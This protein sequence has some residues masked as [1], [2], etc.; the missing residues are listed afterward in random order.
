[1]IKVHAQI[2]CKRPHLS[3]VLVGFLL[4]QQ[5]GL[6]DFSYSFEEQFATENPYLS[7]LFA[8]IDGKKVVFDMNDGYDFSFEAVNQ[9]LDNTDF[10]FKR[11][12]STEKNRQ[13]SPQNRSKLYRW[14]LN[15]HVTCPGNPLDQ[16]TGWRALKEDIFQIAANGA[17]RSYFTPERFE[18]GAGEKSAG[19]ILFLARLWEPIGEPAVDEDRTQINRMRIALVERMRREY[20]S[21]F[22]GGIQ[23]SAYAKKLAPELLVPVAMTRRK[24]FLHTVKSCD[25][26]IGT[27][28]LF[29][30]VGWKTTEYV[31]AARAIINEKL[32]YEAPGDFSSPKNYL[33]FLTADDCMEKTAYLLE[34]P[35]AVAQ[36][37]RQNEAYYQQWVRPD[38]KMRHALALVCGNG[39]EV[40]V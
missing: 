26:C 29:G 1:M 34:H 20:G 17:R 9:I 25:I 30:S 21:R 4:L 7:Y 10:Y 8:D 19:N 28:G 3:E 18:S 2:V 32:Q 5:A 35:E 6:V 27:T 33:E 14:G 40:L 11:S 15:Y 38:Q 12:F 37:K 39:G 31:A 22:L 24:N 16:Q 13:F 36:M 23:Y